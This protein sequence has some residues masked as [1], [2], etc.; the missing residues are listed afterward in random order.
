[1]A[2]LPASVA[3]SCNG[4]RPRDVVLG[5]AD[6]VV[7]A[8]NVAAAVQEAAMVLNR[9]I[10]ERVFVGATE[11]T[12]KPVVNTGAGG[13]QRALLMDVSVTGAGLFGPTYPWVRE[14]DLVI[15]GF[16]NARAVVG[17]RRVSPTDDADLRYYRVEFVSPEPA[18]ERE[19]YEVI[20]RGRTN[21][22]T[23]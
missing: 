19:V 7:R 3:L 13:A 14:G 17:V 18:F 9:R 12:W 16:N 20:G 21:H 10:G 1:M 22:P 4:N 6:F 11:L 8:A 5:A 15:V 2:H 23:P